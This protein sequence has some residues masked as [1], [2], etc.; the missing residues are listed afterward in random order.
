MSK[1]S[2]LE[3]HSRTGSPV[4]LKTLM[5]MYQKDRNAFF[6]LAQTP[7]SSAQDEHEQML[8]EL[9]AEIRRA[10]AEGFEF[11]KTTPHDVSISSA[12]GSIDFIDVDVAALEQFMNDL[13]GSGSQMTQRGGRITSNAE[14][15]FKLGDESTWAS[16]LRENEVLA[17]HKPIELYLQP[18]ELGALTSGMPPYVVHSLRYCAQKTV[19][20]P[21]SVFRGLRTAAQF[22]EAR[23][24]CGRPR[25]AVDNNGNHIAPPE[26]K[27]YVVF[28]DSTGHVFDWDWV[29]EDA[30][31]PGKPLEF[32]SRFVEEIPLAEA[33]I[34]NL[35]DISTVPKFNSQQAWYSSTGDCIFWYFSDSIAYAQWVN[36][37]LTVFRSL[38]DELVT[39][40]KLKN[41]ESIIDDVPHVR[42][43]PKDD[44]VM[45]VLAASFL[46]QVEQGQSRKDYGRLIYEAEQ[47]RPSIL[48]APV[49]A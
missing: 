48:D 20:A 26:R 39:G 14:L 44:A 18:G 10:L 32:S 23:A 49:A 4:I 29:E 33:T 34:L 43:R 37:D 25:F 41:I 38:D 45:A 19:Q 12:S 17:S 24:Y 28:S 2:D 7:V 30:D 1:T 8:I 9:A 27:I 22:Q 36:D 5:S 11:L 15:V 3:P 31:Y 21:T 13:N 40:F 6:E 35:P 47:R 46:R 42:D 16:V